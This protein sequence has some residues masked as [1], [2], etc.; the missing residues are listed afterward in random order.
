MS[1]SLVLRLLLWLLY[2]RVGRHDLVNLHFSMFCEMLLK[3]RKL[4]QR[5]NTFGGKKRNFY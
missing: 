3:F 4:F 5:Y 2:V 1:P